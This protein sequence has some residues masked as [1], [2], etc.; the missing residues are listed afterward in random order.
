MGGLLVI[1]LLLLIAMAQRVS[2]KV[3]FTFEGKVYRVPT[4]YRDL[5][6]QALQGNEKAKYAIVTQ[7]YENSKPFIPE[8]CFKFVSELAEKDLGVLTELG[9]LYRDGIGTPKDEA[10]SRAV[11]TRA[12]ELYDNPPPGLYIPER[13]KKYRSFLLENSDL[14]KIKR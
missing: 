2:S 6:K 1:L 10:K 9:D 14:S 11:Y 4:K 7:Y 3:E 8:L 5:A 13:S 12:L